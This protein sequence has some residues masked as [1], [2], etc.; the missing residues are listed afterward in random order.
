MLKWNGSECNET[1]TKTRAAMSTQWTNRNENDTD[2]EKPY[3]LWEQ[4]RISRK[5]GVHVH[6]MCKKTQKL[7]FLCLLLR[8][9]RHS[10]FGAP[11]TVGVIIE[12]LCTFFIVWCIHTNIRFKFER[13]VYASIADISVVFLTFAIFFVHLFF[14]LRFC[15]HL[16]LLKDDIKTMLNATL[17]TKCNWINREERSST[18]LLSFFFLRWKKV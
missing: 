10:F 14:C 2:E 6:H 9:L 15:C 17:T 12:R 8:C 16:C 11:K 18:E 5:I 13:V 3:K 1:E 4:V 7:F